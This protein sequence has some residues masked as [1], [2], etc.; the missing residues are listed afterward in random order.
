MKQMIYGAQGYALGAFEA[1]KTIYPDREILC[2]VV[3][4]KDGNTATLGGKPVRTLAEVAEAVSDA[5]RSDLEFLIATPED[6][7][8]EIVELLEQKGFYNHKG[9][10]SK[11]WN[12]LMT[13]SHSAKGDFL[14]LSVIQAGDKPLKAE[15]YMAK[16]HKDR[17]L[18]NGRPCP[19][20]VH[21]IQVGA[22]NT[23]MRIADIADNEGQ[24]ISDRNANY[25]ELTG[26]YWIWKNRLCDDVT[27][28]DD[29]CYGLEQYR[30]GFELSEEDL[31]RLASGEVDVLLPWPLSYEPDINV[32]HERYIKDS[33]WE[34]LNVALKEL[35]P[36]YAAYFPLVLNQGSLYNYNIIIAKGTIL[37]EYCEWLFPILERV[38]EISSPKENER[39]DRYIGYMGESLETLF[40]MKNSDRLKIAHTASKLYI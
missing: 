18:Q 20:Y 2:F 30:R 11:L 26:L 25:C 4:A 33:D 19:A 9:L 6:V 14:P 31:H 24:N 15:I 35:Q 34:S 37:R 10:D 7:Q 8:P 3:T 13:K 29:T 40:F 38:G 39:S 23:D 22:D 17:T 16:S 27:S 1:I 5:D 36:E 12:E 28:T 32:H 21:P